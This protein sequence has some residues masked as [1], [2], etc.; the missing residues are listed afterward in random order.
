MLLSFDFF[1]DINLF[2]IILLKSVSCLYFIDVTSLFYFNVQVTYDESSASA[3][4]ISCF[5]FFLHLVFVAVHTIFKITISELFKYYIVDN[6]QR[7]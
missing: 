3:F 5:D 2:I 7:G 4:K 1:L 6:G